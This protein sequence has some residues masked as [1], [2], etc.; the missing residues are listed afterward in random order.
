MYMDEAYVIV[1][2]DWV[3]EASGLAPNALNMDALVADLK[4]LS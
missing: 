4:A 1:T 2:P 3:N